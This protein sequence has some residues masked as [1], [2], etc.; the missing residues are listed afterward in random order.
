MEVLRT[1][2]VI[3]TTVVM[4]LM[5]GV[6]FLYSNTIMPGLRKTDD[7]TFVGA[8]QAIDTRI[9]N[10]PFMFLFFGGVVLSGVTVFLHFDDQFASA[11]PTLVAAFVLYV[12]VFIL[13][14]AINVPLNN[15]IKAAGDPTTIDVSQVRSRFNEK[16][17][18]RSN[19]IRTVLTLLA[20]ACLC[21]A[22]L[23]LG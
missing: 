11:V 23:E 18:I 10:P 14:V 22:L 20:F 19:H 5:G 21:W 15:Y 4:G 1:V 9:I 13:T 7:Q 3:A 6:F 16:R 12:V 17:W 2:L 8:F